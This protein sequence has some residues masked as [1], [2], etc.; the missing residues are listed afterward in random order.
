M[1]AISV[2]WKYILLSAVGCVYD[3]DLMYSHLWCL[4]Q[5]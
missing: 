2:E 5:I 1:Y 4:G 3:H